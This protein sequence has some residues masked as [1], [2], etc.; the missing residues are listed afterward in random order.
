MEKWMHICMAPEPAG[1][2][3]QKKSTDREE[4]KNRTQNRNN[5]EEL[6]KRLRNKRQRDGGMKREQRESEAKEKMERE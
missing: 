6:G 2:D 5:G 4:K 3:K 1:N